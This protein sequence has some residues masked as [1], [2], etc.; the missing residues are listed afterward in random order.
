MA[1]KWTDAQLAA[2]NT[3]NKTLLL[4][5]AAGSGKTT[6]LTQRIISSITDPSSPA[7]I[8]KMLIVTF[9]RASAAD[10][11][12]KIFNAVSDALALDPSNKHLS[13]QLIKLG[14]AKIS[15]IDSF[16]LAAVKQNFAALG[17]SSSFRIADSSETD[18]LA[19]NVMRD[20]VAYFYETDPAFP[21]LCECFEKIRDNEDVMEEVL[22][23]LY[24]ECM[25]TPEGV[26]Y[27][28]IS[29]ERA[30]ADANENLLES[31]YGKILTRYVVGALRGHLEEYD[32]VLEL[33][34]T[35]ER[36]MGA[37]YE[38]MNSD[39]V[40][41]IEVLDAID[42]LED[43]SIISDMFLGYSLPS[44]KAFRNPTELSSYCKALRD[45]FKSIFTELRDDFF[46]YSQD[47]FSKFFTMTAERLMTLWAVLSRFETLYSQEKSR[48]NILEL[49]DVKRYALKLFAN[50]DGTPT[51]LALSYSKQFTDIY[52]DE[53]Q[54]VDPVQDLIFRCIATPTNRF[55]VGDIKQSIYSFRGA[56][57]QLFADY[58]SAF[59]F[60]GSE[61]AEEADCQTIFMS[62]NFR[63]ARHIIDFTND[64]CAPIF[65]ACGSSIGYTQG[66]DLVCARP[67]DKDT[68]E[69][70]RV[71]VARFAKKSKK[72]L[73]DGIDESALPSAA[74]AEAEYVAE[75]ICQL[76]KSGK[77]ANGEPLKPCDIA[78]LFRSKS[79]ARRISDAL[80]QRG[81]PSNN[82]ESA[83]YFQNPDVMMMLCI[84]NTVDNPQRDIYLAG[85]LRS[86]I[87]SFSLDE[88]LQ[89][90]Q[91]GEP[92][93]SLYDKLCLLSEE[94]TPLGE[95]CKSFRDTLE[96]WRAV[97]VSMPID[98]LLNFIFSTETFV[99]S[100]LLSHT[101]G[102][103]QGGNLLRLYDYARI[104]EAGSFKGLYNF[105]EFINSIIE[106]G[107][108]IDTS[109]D[110]ASNNAV[111]LTTIHK[112]KG[113]EY[114]VC[115]VCNAAASFKTGSNNR[116]LSFEYGIGVAMTL[117]DST[118]FAYYTSPLKRILDLNSHLK[119]VEEEMRILYVALTR[120]KEQLYVTGSYARSVMSGVVA[121]SD[122][123]RQFK[124]EYSV[125]S[126]DSYMD[127]V[128]PAIDPSDEN[129]PARLLCYTTDEASFGKDQL[130][131]TEPEG[132]CQAGD[133]EL[134][135]TLRNRFAFTYPYEDL[136]NLPAK[137][138][139][140]K[141]S[142]DVL[143]TSDTSLQMF[144]R[145][146][147]VSVP[148]FFLNTKSK[149]SAAQRGTATHLALQFCDFA[150]LKEKG[151]KETLDMLIQK[152]FIPQS[153][154]EA[155]FVEEL[156]RLRES[157]LMDKLIG[158]KR[159]IREQRFST[160]LSASEFTRDP[161]LK[162]K[163]SGEAIA[164]QGVIDLII[165]DRDGKVELFDYK[166]DRLSSAELGNRELAA[167]R[168]NERHGLQMAYY[169]KAVTALFG[170]SPSRVAIY[171]THSGLIYDTD[172]TELSFPED[173][174]IPFEL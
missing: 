113:L 68:F 53:Y 49:T 89:I 145:E 59:P 13:S 22:L 75:T 87:F 106:N 170:R 137:L 72:E 85:A 92:S 149:P 32:R 99:A 139:V 100:G 16:Y 132:E 7:D 161:S 56:R 46:C 18:L 136:R 110:G 27:L 160:L 148:D 4:S 3:K 155:V 10:L 36:L 5:A 78:I 157:E 60:R 168:M 44:L 134:Y 143:D 114:P 50:E 64:V 164:V 55:M 38:Q 26:E 152:G 80:A 8:S 162:E 34:E 129:A 20:I 15:T 128:C 112:S 17:L 156:D 142:P 146:V 33:M 163:L 24:T 101:D 116:D 127:W 48:R 42:R 84:L 115:F 61:G 118:G 79:A 11:R 28:R 104:F 151:A 30:L 98:K 71:T 51:A 69:L 19:K 109:G 94:A 74:E 125:F 107:Q 35:D 108:T 159:I 171:S 86:P 95:K 165:V 23:G 102:S 66:D 96:R 117:S 140:S 119:G 6:T 39:R 12:T 77:R 126:A 158:A 93:H 130:T 52:I 147:S 174:L 105:I 135:E 83:Q 133:R 173:S 154:A 103:G 81:I 120:A 111:T 97:S 47:E 31:E 144:D 167:R 172:T 43:F 153:T 138:S 14:S 124:C 2:I 131:H 123:R 91:A 73:P 122:F 88:L 40:F 45:S 25:R 82:T 37:Y 1:T 65:S 58:R 166:T 90:S 63:C 62:E 67:S 70:P 76:L 150:F 57:P 141:L 169:R 29:G 54:D 121:S 21:S 41:C 9:T